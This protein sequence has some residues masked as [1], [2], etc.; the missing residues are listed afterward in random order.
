MRTLSVIFGK[1]IYFTIYELYDEPLLGFWGLCCVI[2]SKYA[3]QIHLHSISVRNT[4]CYAV[5][6]NAEVFFSL[7]ASTD[8]SL[9]VIHRETQSL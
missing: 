1:S 2:C 3:F 7:L 9:E 6:P 8:V 4:D 5:A